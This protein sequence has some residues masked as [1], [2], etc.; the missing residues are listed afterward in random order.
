[1][2]YDLN[3]AIPYWG[4]NAEVWDEAM[5]DGS[6]FQ[7]V[8]VEPHV[9]QFL[10]VQ[11]NQRVL[12]I[13]C[14][15]GQ[16]S[17]V[18]ARMGACVT[19]IDGSAQMI[20]LAKDR[21]QGLTIDYHVADI[22]NNKTLPNLKNGQFD[23][24]LCNMALMD[25]AEIEPVFQLAHK[26]LKDAGVFVFSISHPCFD[27]SVG[28]HVTEL[29]EN[30]GTSITERFIKVGRYLS[31]CVLKTRALPSFPSPHFFF[32]RSL[33]TYL[34]AAFDQG[35]MMCGVAESAFPQD[36]NFTV[37][38]GWHELPSIPVVF[39]AKFRK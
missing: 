22:A 24:V 19:A 35:L 8:L 12:D 39:I 9:L 13:A 10:N 28:P 18:L 26:V 4:L 16:M 11:P 14:G 29:H 3:Q 33:E 2:T 25:I 27:K 17:R 20:H 31:S 38:R 15:N 6:L 5:A 7:K 37:H 34:N 21:S 23:A 36:A 32:H 30:E 1:M